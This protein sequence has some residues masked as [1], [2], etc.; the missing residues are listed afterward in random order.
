VA[1]DGDG[2]IGREIV[3]IVFEGDEAERVDEAVGGIASDNVDLVIDEGSVEEAE[4]HDIGRGGEVE[5]VA[6]APAGETV[7]A[8]EKFVAYAG[9]PLGG[10]GG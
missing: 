6:G 5:I 8:F 4:V 2:V 10:D 9:M 7:G 3:Q 1:D